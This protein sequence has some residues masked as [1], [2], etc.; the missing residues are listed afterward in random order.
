MYLGRNYDSAETLLTQLIAFLDSISG[1]QLAGN[2]A[3]F[4]M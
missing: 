2:L 4:S 3:F 1:I